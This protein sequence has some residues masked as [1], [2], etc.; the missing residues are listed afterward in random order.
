M[1]YSGDDAGEHWLEWEH[2]CRR[3]T[4]P[5]ADVEDL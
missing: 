4:T 3:A 1:S 2:K 5:I